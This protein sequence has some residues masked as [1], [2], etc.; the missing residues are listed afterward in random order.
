MSPPE[1][2]VI[3]TIVIEGKGLE[4]SV[5]AVEELE[6]PRL[7]ML[8]VVVAEDSRVSGPL[9]SRRALDH[10]HLQPVN[11]FRLDVAVVIL[12]ELAARQILEGKL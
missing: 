11:D 2:L 3:T 9:I 6:P 8:R 4:Q 1:P 5:P 12:A 10:V 7:Q